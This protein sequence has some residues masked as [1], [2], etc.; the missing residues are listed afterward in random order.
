MI[1]KTPCF[2]GFAVSE[3]TI[4]SLYNYIYNHSFNYKGFALPQNRPITDIIARLCLLSLKSEIEFLKSGCNTMLLIRECNVA[5]YAIQCCL[6]DLKY[7]GKSRVLWN[8][9]EMCS[10][11]IPKILDRQISCSVMSQPC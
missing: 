9:Q 5:Y 11:R 1:F 7:K 8:C 4:K 3:I 6:C 2:R 10:R